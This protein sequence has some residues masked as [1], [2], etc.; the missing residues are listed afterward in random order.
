MAKWNFF[1]IWNWVMPGGVGSSWSFNELRVKFP[2]EEY[3][4]VAVI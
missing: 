4:P 1:S 3:P 2:I